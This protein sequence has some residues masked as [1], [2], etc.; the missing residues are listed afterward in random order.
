MGETYD[1]LRRG[2][3]AVEAYRQA[4]S[5]IDDNGE[6]FYRLGRL[7]LDRGD[8]GEA[9]NIALTKVRAKSWWVHHLFHVP[10]REDG[11]SYLAVRLPSR[12]AFCL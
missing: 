2:R 4:T 7:A 11:A 10:F 1:Q 8:T 6:W 5:H 9:A 3:E 12:T